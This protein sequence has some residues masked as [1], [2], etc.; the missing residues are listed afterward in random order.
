[1]KITENGGGYIF[2]VV[3]PTK[4]MTLSGVGVVGPLKFSTFAFVCDVYIFNFHLTVSP[5][6]CCLCHLCEF[7]LL[8]FVFLYSPIRL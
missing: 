7:V 8:P 1:M 5:F 2:L 4:Y 6:L 3:K